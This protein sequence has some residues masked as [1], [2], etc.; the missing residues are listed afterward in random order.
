MKLNDF[1]NKRR[2]ELSMSV[3]DLV[4]KSGIP[5][6]TLSKITAGINSNPTLSTIEA[7]CKALDCSLND[8][9]GNISSDIFSPTETNI[10]KKYR[11]LDEYGKRVINGT[12]E[13]EYERCTKDESE[14][15]KVQV[16]A[17]SNKN[18]KPHSE[19]ITKAENDAEDALLQDPDE[20]M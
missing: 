1:V 8:I 15:I 5:K 9:I 14:L 18:T 19:Y 7:L 11:T 4:K 10:I 16:A 12:L 17:R 2:K 13:I 6:G 3:D 20:D